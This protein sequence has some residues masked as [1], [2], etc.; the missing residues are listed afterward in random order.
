MIFIS[1]HNQTFKKQ[2]LL[3]AKFQITDVLR[4]IVMNECPALDG[5]WFKVTHSK[6]G[7]ASY[8]TTEEACPR[9]LTIKANALLH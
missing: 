6:T 8:P 1:I 7:L 3:W 2:T 4:A 5:A 9:P